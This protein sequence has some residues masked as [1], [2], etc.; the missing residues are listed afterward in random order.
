MRLPLRHIVWFTAA[1]LAPCLGL[2]LLTLRLLDQEQQLASRRARENEER[3]LDNARRILQAELEP[4]RL[5]QA[6]AAFRGTVRGGRVILTWDEAM[7]SK[8]TA[9]LEQAVRSRDQQAFEALA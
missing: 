3:Q 7:A 1:V 4:Y 9:R 2:V 8:E 5:G 6:P